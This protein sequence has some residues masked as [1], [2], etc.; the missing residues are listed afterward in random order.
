MGKR[1]TNKPTTTY[2]IEEF[3]DVPCLLDEISNFYPFFKGPA[4]SSTEECAK[5]CVEKGL[6]GFVALAIASHRPYSD[7]AMKG[8][9]E[10]DDTCMCFYEF[11]KRKSS[12]SC[13]TLPLPS[14]IL[15]LKNPMVPLLK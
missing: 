7:D 13:L 2:K 3:A 4:E 15:Q 9:L 6:D 10:F 11:G 14:F 8:D 1:S 5:F 12:P